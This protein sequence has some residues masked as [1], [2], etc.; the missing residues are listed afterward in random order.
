MSWNPL[1]SA[2]SRERSCPPCTLWSSLPPRCTLGLQDLFDYG[3]FGGGSR[4][5][6][7]LVA[8]PAN[9]L[10]TRNGKKTV[11]V[12]QGIWVDFLEMCWK[13]VSDTVERLNLEKLK[14]MTTGF[15]LPVPDLDLG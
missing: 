1:L 6:S 3:K 11:E 14:F 7:A 4:T 10:I 5:V 15:W 8:G 13:E 2:F 9:R 12:F